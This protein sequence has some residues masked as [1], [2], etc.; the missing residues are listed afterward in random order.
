M[1]EKTATEKILDTI[2][3]LQ[4]LADRAGTPEEAA[5]A[6]ARIQALLFK[7]NLELADVALHEETVS[8]PDADYEQDLY[9]L[10]SPGFSKDRVG[11]FHLGWQ[12]HLLHVVAEANFCTTVFHPQIRS[13]SIIGQRHNIEMV[14]FLFEYLSREIYRLSREALVLHCESRLPATMGA[15]TRSFCM[16]ATGVVGRRLLEQKRQDTVQSAQSTALV[17]VNANALQLAQDRMFGKLRK[18]SGASGA[19]DYSAT[20]LGREAGA[21][22]ALNKPLG[23]GSNA[24]RLGQ[25]R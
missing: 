24:G 14:K 22:I 19:R 7:H 1:A 11:A 20:R 2:K 5:A 15:W 16:G 10:R 18:G 8:E 17:R 9:S 3:K 6:A 13:Q 12:K 4:R 21:R 23:S 25:G